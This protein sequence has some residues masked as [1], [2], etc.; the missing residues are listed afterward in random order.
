[1]F[2]Q[3]LRLNVSVADSDIE[4]VRRARKLL[5]KIGLSTRHRATRKA[6]YRNILGYHHEAQKLYRD[7]RF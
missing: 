4:V 3:Y 2:S 1:M 6:W 7:F 5:S